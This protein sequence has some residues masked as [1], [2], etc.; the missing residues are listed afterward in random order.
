MHTGITGVFNDFCLSLE[1]CGT[2]NK[3]RPK[4]NRF[5]ETSCIRTRGTTQIASVDAPS[6][7]DKPYAFTRQIRETPTSRISAICTHRIS[8]SEAI[9][10]APAHT[11]FHQPPA[12]WGV[13]GTILFVTAFIG[14]TIVVYTPIF[15]YYTVGRTRCQERGQNFFLYDARLSCA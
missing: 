14:C 5:F 13:T 8:G 10:T 9:D 2:I 4:E 3:K 1:R 11:G 15:F 7:S 12:L 6:G